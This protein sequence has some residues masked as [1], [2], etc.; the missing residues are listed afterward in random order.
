MTHAHDSSPAAS[1]DDAV[2]ATSNE[3][4]TARSDPARIAGLASFHQYIQAAFTLRRGQAGW[5][6]GMARRDSCA[7]RGIRACLL[8]NAPSDAVTP[9]RIAS[10][11]P[12]GHTQ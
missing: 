3:Q 8:V 1:D 12:Y 9:H 11:S 2:R 6:F 10:T 7:I 5:A 4:P